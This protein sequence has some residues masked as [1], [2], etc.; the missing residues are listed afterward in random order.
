M[1]W[2]GLR[3][4]IGVGLTMSTIKRAEYGYSGFK[5]SK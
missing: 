5:L 4:T 3:H 2:Y 1:D